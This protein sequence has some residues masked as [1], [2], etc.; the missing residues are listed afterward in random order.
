[1]PSNYLYFDA[2]MHWFV[3]IFSIFTLFGPQTLGN[4]N[5]KA[6]GRNRHFAKRNNSK[7][8]RL[9]KKNF[10]QSLLK[11]FRSDK[12]PFDDSVKIA[13]DLLLTDHIVD[14]EKQNNFQENGFKFDSDTVEEISKKLNIPQVIER[15]INLGDIA[16]TF[17][18][19]I[20][21][22]TRQVLEILEEENV[23]ATF[24][25]LGNTLDDPKNQQVVNEVLDKMKADGHTISSHSYSHPNF[26]DLWPEGIQC[27]MDK[28]KGL[29]L[30]R[31]GKAPR[32]M[33]PPFG[34]I[35]SQSI[36]SLN[37]LGYFIIKW[38]LDTN[39]WMYTEAPE[40]S[41]SEFREKLPDQSKINDIKYHKR[42]L[43]ELGV[44][45][46]M[47]ALLDSKIVLMHDVNPGIIPALP[48]L[49]K[50]AKEL[51]YRFVSMEECLGGLNPYFDS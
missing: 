30:E 38:N 23:K 31:L 33:R 9:V 20:S 39:D 43:T 42:G 36:K 12:I 50:Y 11:S 25:I 13:E 40:K 51:G 2:G 27:E 35:N 28:T 14:H 24:F 1:M 7:P 3:V 6:F 18:D 47:K 44:K 17:D 34:N 16:L 45:T 41:F 4:Q 22:Y 49:I 29:F 48:R 8:D 21:K 15:C 37:D 10:Q 32:F 19:G 5:L 46:M 26:D